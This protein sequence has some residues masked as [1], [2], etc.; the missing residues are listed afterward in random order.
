MAASE[1]R[2]VAVQEVVLCRAA[3]Y[4]YF[5]CRLIYR[6]II[7]LVDLSIDTFF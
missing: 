3:A 7:R 6:L 2:V 5:Y 1:T 4:N